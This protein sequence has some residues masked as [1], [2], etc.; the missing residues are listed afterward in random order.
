MVFANFGEMAV[1]REGI[2]LEIAHG[3]R[4]T[5]YSNRLQLSRCF[6]TFH[7]ASIL[8]GFAGLKAK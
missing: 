4:A 2:D 3:C 8:H 5:R 7:P 6:I 1:D